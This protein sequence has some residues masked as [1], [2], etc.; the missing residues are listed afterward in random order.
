MTCRLVDGVYFERQTKQVSA[1][2]LTKSKI[3]HC[4]QNYTTEVYGVYGHVLVCVK[5]GVCLEM[6]TCVLV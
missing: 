6:C 3:Q 4:I 5:S 1:E 2:E